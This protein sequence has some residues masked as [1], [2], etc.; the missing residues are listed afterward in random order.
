[1]YICIY[2]CVYIV[3]F[4]HKYI[5]IYARVY[6]IISQRIGYLLLTL[7]KEKLYKNMR[8]VQ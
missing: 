6:A 5:L 4:V 3:M 2:V 8:E 7:N 1:M